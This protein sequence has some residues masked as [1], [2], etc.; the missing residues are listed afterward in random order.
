MGTLNGTT[1]IVV[2]DTAGLSVNMILSGSNIPTGAYITAIN[3]N[4]SITISVAATGSGTET[5]TV[6][7]SY[8]VPATTNPGSLE[9]TVRQTLYSQN[10]EVN[11]CGCP[12][13]LAN[14]ASPI[15]IPYEAVS[16]MLDD[17]GHDT[18]V[19]SCTSVG[20]LLQTTIQAVSQF[21]Q[22]YNSPVIMTGGSESGHAPPINNIYSH[23]NGYKVDLIDS[24]QNG[25]TFAGLL[26]AFIQNNFDGL[27]RR[28]SDNCL[29]YGMDLIQSNP[30]PQFAFEGYGCPGETH[31]DIAF[32]LDSTAT[33]NSNSAG[34]QGGGSISS[35]PGGIACGTPSAGGGANCMAQFTRGMNVNLAAVPDSLSIFDNWTGLDS[36]TDA[37]NGANATI[38]ADGQRYITVT[39]DPLTGG[40]GGPPP[41]PPTG[42]GP[43]SWVW[44]PTLNGGLG[45]WVWIGATPLPTSGAPPPTWCWSWNPTIGGGAWIH[46]ICLPCT[47]FSVSN[48]IPGGGTTVTTLTS[49]DPNEKSGPHGIGSA[50]YLSASQKL[51]YAIF[52]DNDPTATAPAQTVTVSDTLNGA[53]LDLTTV[54][55]GPISFVDTVITPPSIPLNLVGT[56]SANADLRPAQSLIIAVTAA[57]NSSTGTLT[58][59]FKSLD[60]ATG[61]P[62]TN[63]VIG[64]LPPGTEGS[65]SFTASPLA[66][67]T[68]TQVSN[69]ATVVFDFNPP[70]STPIWT[71]TF[72]ST[73]PVSHVSALPATSTC[74]D[75]R[76]SWSGSD[77]GSG[78][79]G[80]TIF[81]SDGGGAFT[82]WVSNTSAAAAT[83]MGVVGH[84]YSFY[85]IATDLAGNPEVG[86]ISGEASATVTGAGPCGPPSLSG[87]VSNVI[88]SGT[89][90]TATLTLNNT[91]FTPAQAVNI[92]Q[93]T[94][95]TLSGSGTVTLASPVIPAAEGPLDIGA[96][97]AVPVTLNVPATVTR[98]SMTESGNL[99][100]GSANNYNYSMAQ[101]VIP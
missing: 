5:I 13:D 89:T 36:T 20:G 19:G 30:G 12:I 54:T 69:T 14:P 33:I 73:P 26:F 11:K 76:V 72:D 80:F 3:P 83:Y 16:D 78:L 50:R 71:N 53:T 63:P 57:L 59:T 44:N 43:G 35:A 18:H 1:T 40:G 48:C 45:G 62:T 99:Q 96:S 51:S 82:P 24:Y 32:P 87:Q 6:G 25:S 66:P 67:V 21:E 97:T 38:Y 61:L 23:D 46:Q 52:F 27:G 81:V 22:K 31:A 92:N 49:G 10:I 79:H 39:F 37:V 65:V 64:V 74:P 34:G 91:G 42:S 90:V 75:F 94:F 58:W 77:V 85:S 29:K 28:S 95:R 2:S 100:D 55:L 4:T 84:T 60:P 101:T 47:Q 7:P 56:F 41:P 68:G 98:F 8:T 88:Q 86:K 70:I 93:V 17:T 15:D 9:A